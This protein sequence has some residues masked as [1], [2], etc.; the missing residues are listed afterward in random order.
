MPASNATSRFSDRVEN[1]IRY[2]PGYP[3]Q[4]LETLRKECG[5]T[6]AHV[7]ADVASGTGIWTR[8]LLENG[9]PVYGVEPNLDMRQASERLLAGFPR[10]ISV[11]GRAEATTLDNASVDFVTAAQAAHWFDREQA[12]Q[13]LSRILKPDGW[14]VLL[15]N[16][17]EV[18]TT[19]FLREYEELLLTY[20]TDYA[21]VRHERT[22]DS[23]NEFFD[24]APY[25]ERVFPMRQ[26][27]DYE[28]LE[29]RLLSSSYAPGPGHPKHEPMLREL[30]RIFDERAIDGRVA[31]DYKTRV[32]F[33][34]LA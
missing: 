15:W 24:P 10:F 26:E 12:Q 19:P 29:G 22:T 31:F 33:G 20:G 25:Q 28:G 17:R 8:T 32:Y 18:D 7:I 30:R 6:P 2:R 3:P 4:V 27:F 9:N 23:V 5:L 21:D 16:E 13:E 11:D 14:L 1:Y 34:R